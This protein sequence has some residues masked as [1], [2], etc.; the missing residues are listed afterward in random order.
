MA[1]YTQ[2][3]SESILLTDSI[4]QVYD[5]HTQYD[6]HVFYNNTGTSNISRV[7]GWNRN[8]TD[9]VSIFD[10]IADSI[11]ILAHLVDTVFVNDY[12]SQVVSFNKIL[13]DIVTTQDTFTSSI[14]Y[15]RS[16]NDVLAV[17]DTINYLTSIAIKLYDSV[18]LSDSANVDFV[19][20]LFLQDDINL[21]DYF[22]YV[23]T[24]DVDNDTAPT[25]D[26]LIFK[27]LPYTEPDKM[28]L[29]SKTEAPTTTGLNFVT[30]GTYVLKQYDSHTIYNKHIPYYDSI[31]TDEA[32]TILTITDKP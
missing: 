20:Y 25:I 29:Y 1:A 32:P 16:N 10:Y 3:F 19:K 14:Q 2:N 31:G 22:S 21:T 17:Q 30:G 23:N 7:L 11:S 24:N 13:N 28:I 8:Q 5:S 9:S 27:P 6:D 26:I 15:F 18:G 12:F 4:G